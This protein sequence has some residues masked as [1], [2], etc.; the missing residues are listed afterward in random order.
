VDQLRNLPAVKHVF[1]EHK[2]APTCID[3]RGIHCFA[4][5]SSS[6]VLRSIAVDPVNG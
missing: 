3:A 4:F 2:Y 5:S 6:I 1:E